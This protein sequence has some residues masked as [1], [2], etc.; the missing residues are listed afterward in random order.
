M[1]DPKQEVFHFFDVVGGFEGYTVVHK[2]EVSAQFDL[3]LPLWAEGVVAGPGR[4]ERTG[5]GT[6]HHRVQRG[7]NRPVCGEVARLSECS[8]DFYQAEAIAARLGK[9]AEC[10]DVDGCRS[11]RVV[12]QFVCIAVVGGF[13]SPDAHGDDYFVTPVDF[14]LAEKAPVALKDA[15]LDVVAGAGLVH[16]GLRTDQE[17]RG[18]D[19]GVLIE[20]FSRRSQLSTEV[21]AAAVDAVHQ[22]CIDVAVGIGRV[23]VG[24]EAFRA[25]ATA[26]EL[27]GGWCNDFGDHP[28]VVES[29]AHD[30][31]E[32]LVVA[33]HQV[34]GECD[35]A[36]DAV[37]RLVVGHLL[38]GLEHIG[39]CVGVI[40]VVAVG[41]GVQFGPGGRLR[42]RYPIGRRGIVIVEIAPIGAAAR[43]SAAELNIKP[44]AEF[45]V[46]VQ[47]EAQSLVARVCYDAL[48]IFIGHADEVF[49]VVRAAAHIEAGRA[50]QALVAV[51]FF[52]IIIEFAGCF[53]SFVSV[54]SC[55]LVVCFS[56][57]FIPLPRAK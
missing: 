2:T 42:Q 32:A 53:G 29:A 5:I 36:D 28:I 25:H 49:T 38:H 31:A 56:L 9:T 33:L 45:L 7:I 24:D 54:G 50:E 30:E 48:F 15:A 44:L 26:L 11:A 8:A 22:E 52:F 21:E 13:I 6:E 57:R 20:I 3:C 17:L 39:C 4:D 10:T 18:A 41:I 34:G 14:F 37:D 35:T 16:V 46:Q 47:A 51:E 43:V 55:L 19:D 12:V 23:A 27:E 40:G 1:V